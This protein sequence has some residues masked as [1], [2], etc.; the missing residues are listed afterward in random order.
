MGSMW[1]LDGKLVVAFPAIETSTTTKW[2]PSV[3][4]QLPTLQNLNSTNPRQKHHAPTPET[5]SRSAVDNLH[6]LPSF[7]FLYH[8]LSMSSTPGAKGH[9]VALELQNDKPGGCP[10]KHPYKMA[11][12]AGGEPAGAQTNTPTK[13]VP[14]T[15]WQNRVLKFSNFLY[16]MS[17][18][19]KMAEQGP[20]NAPKN[21]CLKNLY[22]I[23]ILQKSC[24]NDPKKISSTK[25]RT[26][27]AATNLPT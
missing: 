20:L 4:F 18:H 12:L 6:V 19:Y 26:C 22:K 23:S 8:S 5:Q 25:W 15:T 24:S 1:W 11:N 13:W 2:Q 9:V 10:N 17:P 14:T 16:K 3:V 21:H 27:K 7:T